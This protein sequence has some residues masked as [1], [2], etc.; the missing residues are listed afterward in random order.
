LL[1]TALLKLASI[2]HFLLAFTE[3]K[4]S[5]IEVIAANKN[6]DITKV[7]IPK[8]CQINSAALTD[9]STQT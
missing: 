2:S 1:Q 6:K 3:S 7:E 4:V 9:N 5:G 8:L